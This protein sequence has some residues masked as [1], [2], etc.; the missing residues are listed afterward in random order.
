MP[1]CILPCHLRC[2]KADFVRACILRM[3]VFPVTRLSSTSCLGLNA[4]SVACYLW[5]DKIT[6]I[7]P[8]IVTM[9]IFLLPC[10]FTCVKLDFDRIYCLKLDVF[11]LPCNSR[12]LKL[13][14]AVTYILKLDR[15][16]ITRHSRSFKLNFRHLGFLILNL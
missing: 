9:D 11:H 2:L 16:P 15:F 3:V 6:F 10:H 8:C 1:F 7:H 4:F 14:F 13:N 12:C 5:Y